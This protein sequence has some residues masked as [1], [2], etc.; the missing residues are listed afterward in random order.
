MRFGGGK[1]LAEVQPGVPMCVASCRHLLQAIP[2]VVAVVRP[3][4]PAVHVALAKLGVKVVGCARAQEG[5]SASLVCGINAAPQAQAWLVALADM[6]LIRP[7]TI[8]SVASA[9]RAG[10]SIAAPAYRGERGHPVG[11]AAWLR[12]ELLVCSG[13]AGARA[14]L[15]VHANEV[16]LIETDDAGVLADFDTRAQLAARGRTD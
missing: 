14:V 16:H 4:D 8:A 13:D 9:L 11:F 3:G 2:D 12:D 5:M 7:D 15:K 10:A 6:P 1:L